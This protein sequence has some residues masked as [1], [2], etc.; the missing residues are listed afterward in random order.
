MKY[1]FLLWPL[2]G[3]IFWMLY[4]ARGFFLYPKQVLAILA[5]SL[6]FGPLSWL[7]LLFIDF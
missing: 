1:L 7:A 2:V 5:L 6:F 4:S 3:L